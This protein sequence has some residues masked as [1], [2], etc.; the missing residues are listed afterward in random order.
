M[1]SFLLGCLS[2]SLAVAS[3]AAAGNPSRFSQSLSP[4]QQAEVGLEQLNGDQ[5]AILDALVRR[6]AEGKGAVA[7][8]AV[9]PA[10]FSERL[11][12]DELRNSGLVSLNT[13]QR[14]RL[15]GAV[16]QYAHPELAV[17]TASPLRSDLSGLSTK[18]LSRPP[19]IH[20][21]FTLMYGVGSHG[22]SERGGAMEL[23]YEDPSKGLAV[24]VGYSELHTKGGDGFYRPLCRSGLGRYGDPFWR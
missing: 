3:V 10:R 5:I 11:S 2:V 9:A 20:G 15:D 14:Q 22:Y 21:S 12:A 16:Q 1:K 4:A 17:G 23:S 6:D 24:G 19:E 7:P 8:A 13:T 18:T